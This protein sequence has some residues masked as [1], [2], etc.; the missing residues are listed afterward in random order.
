MIQSDI[1]RVV[2]LIENRARAG[3]RM[4]V[5]IAGPPASGKSTLAEG[6]V[7]TIN[8]EG[9]GRVPQAALL[10]MDGYHL[11]NPILESRGLRSRKG[12]PETFD[13]EGFCDAVK[14]LQTTTRITYH[15]R[16]DRQLDLSVAN[17]VAVH[18]ETPVIVVEGNYLLLKAAPWSGLADTFTASVFVC[19]TLDQIRNRLE[20]RWVRYGFSKEVAE[21]RILKNDL[22]NAELVMG[23]SREADLTLLQDEATDRN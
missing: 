20:E 14:R 16:F 3:A 4:I 18:P 8:E 5:A 17:A 12:A 7:Q 19:P 21:Q 11:D 9:Q 10:A 15:P 23:R 2:A 1:Q 22:P 6:L 13:A